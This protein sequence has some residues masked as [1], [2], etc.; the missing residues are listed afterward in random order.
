VIR[1]ATPADAA[2]LVEVY[3]PYVVDTVATFEEVPP[4]EAEMR[5]RIAAGHVWL[6][7]EAGGSVVGFAYGGPHRSRPAY[8][9]S[10]EVSVYLAPHA[11]GRGLG[12][13]LY[14]ALLPVLTRLGY[15]SAFAGIT[16]PNAASV[17]LH[18]AMGFVPVGVYQRAGYKHGAWHDVGWWQYALQVAPLRPAEPMPWDGTL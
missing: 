1:A 12:R 11:G 8:R 10:V 9:W 14:G 17:G 6:V 4:D 15:V 7:A 3:S 18:E 2:A 5:A 13:E 16:L